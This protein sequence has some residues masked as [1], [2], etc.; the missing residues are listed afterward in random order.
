[1]DGRNIYICAG[2]MKLVKFEFKPD[3]CDYKS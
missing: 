1:M 3:A 2:A